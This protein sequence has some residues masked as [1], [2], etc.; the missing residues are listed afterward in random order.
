MPTTTTLTVTWKDGTTSSYIVTSGYAESAD[1]KKIT[2][3]GRRSGEAT[4]GA[5]TIRCDE[6]KDW[7]VT[8]A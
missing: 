3:T 1:G 5:V 4:D 8:T 2:F 7:K 6:C